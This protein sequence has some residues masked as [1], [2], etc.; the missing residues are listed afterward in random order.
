MCGLSCLGSPMKM[1][2]WCPGIGRCSIS[3]PPLTPAARL[4]FGT[5]GRMS[6]SSKSVTTATEWVEESLWFWLAYNNA[7]CDC[8]AVAQ[9]LGIK[10]FYCGSCWGWFSWNCSIKALISCFSISLGKKR[11]LSVLKIRAPLHSISMFTAHLWEASCVLLP[12]VFLDQLWTSP[13]TSVWL[14]CF[15]LCGEVSGFQLG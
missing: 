9:A 4:W 7:T 6:L 3:C 13:S 14:V 2:V 10:C 11:P 1:S 5:S 15:L 12:A 8:K